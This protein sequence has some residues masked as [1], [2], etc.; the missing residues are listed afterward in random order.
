[1]APRSWYGRQQCVISGLLEPWPGPGKPGH[2]CLRAS[3]YEAGEGC[4]EIPRLTLAP[5]R[6]IL[7]CF[8]LR[9]PHTLKTGGYLTCHS[10][11][12]GVHEY[13]FTEPIKLDT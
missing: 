3:C 8:S 2:R 5:V 9:L 4:C 10:D 13:T 12:F 6:D 1:M 11:T 7:S